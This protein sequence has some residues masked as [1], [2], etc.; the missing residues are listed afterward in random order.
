[1]HLKCMKADSVDT[2]FMGTEKCWDRNHTRDCGGGGIAE[3]VTRQKNRGGV[4][5]GYIGCDA[6]SFSDSE[7][8]TTGVGCAV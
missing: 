3:G 2:I 4:G 6:A 7:Q 5:N 1:M 8:Y